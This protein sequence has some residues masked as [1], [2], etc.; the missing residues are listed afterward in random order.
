MHKWLIK[1]D[2]KLFGIIQGIPMYGLMIGIGIIICFLIVRYGCKKK[3]IPEAFEE[4]IEVIGVITIVFG[5]F[6]AALFQS[7]YNYVANPDAG[8]HLAENFTFL[9]GLIGGAGFFLIVYFAYGRKKVGAYLTE[10]LPIAACGILIAHSF[11]RMGCFFAGCC[12]G[13]E[14]TSWIG[15]VFPYSNNPT[16]AVYPTQLFESIFLFVMFLICFYLTFKKD[17]KYTF[18]IYLIS[19]GVFRYFI[20]YLRDDSRGE[21]IPGLS[22]SQFWGLMMIP[23]GIGLYFFLKKQYQMITEKELLQESKELENEQPKGDDL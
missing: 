12:Y 2:D 20:E 10:F 8:F 21:F 23:I 14:T 7:F 18:C 13:K 22:P 3:G 9:G 6:I 17:F 15:M 1:F 5:F 19:Y 4:Y 11:G 16:H